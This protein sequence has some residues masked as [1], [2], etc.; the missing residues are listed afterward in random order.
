MPKKRGHGSGALYYLPSKKLWRGVAEV[1][2]EGRGDKK[3]VQKY[4]HSKSQSECRR[5]LEDLI[6]EIEEHGTP[7][8]KS[9]TV[10]DW[11][12]VWL[13]DHA[14]PHVDPSTFAGYSSAVRRWIDPTIG[15][16]KI[17]TVKPSD[18]TAVH[19]AMRDANR[20]TST[21]KGVH[22]ALSQML[23]QARREGLC[24]KNVAL[25]VTPPGGKGKAAA[26]RK[27]KNRDSLPLVQAAKI[28]TTAADDDLAS[29][30]WL[31][32]LGGPRQTEGLGTLL[33][34]YDPEGRVIYINWK[35]EEVPKRHGCGS[36]LSDGAWP[37]GKIRGAA[38]PEAVWQIPDVFEMRHLFGRWCLTRPKSVVGREIPLIPQHA[39]LID[40]YIARHA[41]E[42]NPHGLLWRNPDGQ[43]ILKKPDAQ[44]WRQLLK[45]SGV[46][47]EEQAHPGMSPVD[48]HMARHTTVTLLASL[49]VDFQIIGEIVGHSTEEVTK[50]YRH[51]RLD[52]KRKAVALLGD[53]VLPGSPPA[54]APSAAHGDRPTA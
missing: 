28:L 14:R 1:P 7:V 33:E 20:A 53:L 32:L 45:R 49:N 41:K 38:C 22:V 46:I 29:L 51:A 48:G 9:V 12:Q 34:D 37:C 27:A 5:K 43:P 10:A 47:T 44:E 42:P 39:D 17:A 50:I 25:D 40:A 23:E 13:T 2:E 54:L 3:R 19:S 36:A 8:D 18:V 26:K 30:W 35:L 31:K 6:A 21:A 15:H 24:R 11:A 16:K 52:E 4:V